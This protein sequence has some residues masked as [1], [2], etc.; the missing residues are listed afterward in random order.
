MEVFRFLSFLLLSIFWFGAGWL[1][2]YFVLEIVPEILTHL[3]CEGA[4]RANNLDPSNCQMW[5][6]NE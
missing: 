2:G 6:Q 3:A 5:K 4:A 1:I